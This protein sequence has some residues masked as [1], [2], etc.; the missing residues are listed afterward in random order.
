MGK[1]K[2][3]YEYNNGTYKGVSNL[4]RIYGFIDTRDGNQGS[5]YFFKKYF[6]LN[7][8]SAPT[9]IP[10]VVYDTKIVSL[11]DFNYSGDIA[12]K[13]TMEWYFNNTTIFTRIYILMLLH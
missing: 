2:N 9:P 3:M 6:G 11:L 4:N 7:Q 10:P 5:T 13:N 8:C 1:P 12:I